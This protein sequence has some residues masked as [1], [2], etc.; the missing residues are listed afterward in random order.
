M[1]ANQDTELRENIAMRMFN[2]TY[3]T[4]GPKLKQRVK[5]MV[6]YI[7]HFENATRKDEMQ[8]QQKTLGDNTQGYVVFRLAELD[9][10]E[11]K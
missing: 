10:K 4:C 11:Q 6:S 3:D 2:I 9:A 5:S 7:K 8:L 1:S